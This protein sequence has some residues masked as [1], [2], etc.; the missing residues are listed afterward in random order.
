MMSLVKILGLNLLLPAL[1]TAH[2]ALEQSDPI[3]DIA[4][5]SLIGVYDPAWSQEYFLGIPYA[6]PP[7]GSLRFS[8]PQSLN[9]SWEEPLVAKDYGA[10]CVSYGVS[11]FIWNVQSWNFH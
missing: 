7:V 6:Q 1:V 11:A 8:T 2:A 10:A 9:E 3:V 5:G 4:N